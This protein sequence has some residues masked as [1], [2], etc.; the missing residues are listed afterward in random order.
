METSAAGACRVAVDMHSLA[1]GPNSPPMSSVAKKAR[2]ST[3]ARSAG[4]AVSRAVIVA[5]MATTRVR[6]RSG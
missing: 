2:R 4:H 5:A 6:G 3:R 1:T